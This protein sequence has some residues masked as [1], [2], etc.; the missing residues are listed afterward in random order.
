MVNHHEVELMAVV[1]LIHFV[2]T[3]DDSLNLFLVHLEAFFVLL[4][5]F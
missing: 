2:Q 1:G 4:A 3:V 5:H